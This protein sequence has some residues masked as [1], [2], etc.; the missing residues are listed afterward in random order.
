[1]IIIIMIV[2]III[3]IMINSLPF[4]KVRDKTKKQDNKQNNKKCLQHLKLNFFLPECM[5][6]Q[7][8]PFQRDLFKWFY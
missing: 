6:Q 8:L 3:I 1:M 2:I 5:F 4:Y 7:P